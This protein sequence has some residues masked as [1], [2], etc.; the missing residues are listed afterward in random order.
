MSWLLSSARVLALCAAAEGDEEDGG[1]EGA[2]EG[3]E[4]AGKKKRRAR[5]GGSTLETNPD[6]LN[7][8]DLDYQI[9]TD[10]LFQKTSASFDEGGAKGM[11]LN[12]L[13]VQN[14]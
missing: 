9:T 4:G 3:A 12:N 13:S 2:E 1:A 10:P 6:N 5:S 11:L 8:K 14:G 7:L